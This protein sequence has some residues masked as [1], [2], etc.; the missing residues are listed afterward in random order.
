M[1]K[2]TNGQFAQKWDIYILKLFPKVLRPSQ[3]GGR[4]ILGAKGQG[5]LE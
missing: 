4:K 2:L 3:K 1:Q 5:R